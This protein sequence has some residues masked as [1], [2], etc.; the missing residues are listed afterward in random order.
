MSK[1]ADVFKRVFI[2]TGFICF[3]SI[4]AL[5]QPAGQ[6]PDSALTLRQCIDYA[7][8]HQPLVNQAL[9]NEAIVRTTNAINLS[10]WYP[11][12][13]AQA[14]LT[15]YNS[16]PTSYI[17]DSAGGVHL[18]KNGVV[19]TFIP[20]LG[21]SQT[22]FNPAL[23]YA[24]RTAP[25]Y[26]QQAQEITDSTKIDIIAGVSKTFYSLLLTLEQIS[27][28]REDTARLGKNVSDTY[29]QYVAGIVD[30]TDYDEAVISLN[31][32]KFQL[33]QAT[34]NLYP[35][36]ATLKQ[37]MGYPPRAQFNVLFDTVQ[38]MNDISFDTTQELQFEKRIEYKVLQTQKAL[39]LANINYYRKAWLP[40][41]GAFFNYDYEFQS[42]SFSDLFSKAYPYSYMGLTLNMPIFT[43]F[44]RTNNIKRARLQSD[45]LDWS[46]LNLKSQIFTEYATAMANYKSNLYNLSISKDNVSLAKKTYDIVALQYQQGVVPYLNVITA[47]SNLITSE[48]SYQNALFQV[49]SSKIDLQKSMGFITVR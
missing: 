37:V 18:Q 26:N 13:N 3:L 8:K 49:L 48:I 12:V 7:L 43:G 22:I 5:S 20:V 10:T 31:N 29:H 14:N 27:V 42:N 41:V 9:V 25:L 30:E 38:M 45:L 19:N 33:K 44:N 40:T 17:V 23:L 34:E 6:V 4:A 46:E 1:N 32:S 36:Y 47:E 15:H 11:Q 2:G 16:R 21:V 24:T 35:Q 28:L 39:Q